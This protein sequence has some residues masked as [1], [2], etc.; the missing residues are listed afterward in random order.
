ML[1]FLSRPLRSALGIAEHEMSAPLQAAE[2]EIIEAASAI[3]RATESIEHHVE[4]VEGLATSVGPLTESVNQ[5]TATMGDLVTLLAPLARAEHEF[6]QVERVFRFP[7]RRRQT[8][9][10]ETP[11]T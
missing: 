2:Q 1:E 6:Q 7:R 10:P 8:P 3:R 5:L 9:P 4:V 11:L